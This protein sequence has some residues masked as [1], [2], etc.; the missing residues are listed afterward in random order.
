MSN[1]LTKQNAVALPLVSDNLMDFFEAIGLRIYHLSIGPEVLIKWDL[2]DEGSR[3]DAR[4][5]RECAK[6]MRDTGNLQF[7]AEHLYADAYP[8]HFATDQD[9]ARLHDLLRRALCGDRSATAILN[10]GPQIVKRYQLCP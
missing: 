7:A 5:L 10:G 3:Q 8:G 4:S 6:W 1:D 2:T 9:R